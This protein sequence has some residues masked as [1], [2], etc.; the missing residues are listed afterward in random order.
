MNRN[1]MN[2]QSIKTNHLRRFLITLHAVIIL[3]LMWE[4][5]QSLFK[6]GLPIL[7]ITDTILLA[8]FEKKLTRKHLIAFLFIFIGS[9]LVEVMA[10]KTGHIF[11]V[12]E[13][14]TTLG[15]QIWETPL[16]I[17]CFWFILVYCVYVIFYRFPFPSWLKAIL[18]ATTLVVFDAVLEPVA[19]KLDMWYWIGGL[20]TFQ[21]F[22]AWF[23]T[24]LVFIDFIHL[25]RIE[26]QNKVAESLFAVLF[27]FIIGLYFLLP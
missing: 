25:L 5:T 24:T 8:L 17:G 22:L 11:G 1:A 21:N 6:K 20:V 13:F 9:F 3:G 18:G 10:V 26:P 19:V 7:L 4:P 12:F 2:I 23:I 27:L 14:G 16:T 15:P